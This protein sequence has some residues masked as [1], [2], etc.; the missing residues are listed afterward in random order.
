[1]PDIAQ[2]IPLVHIP[3]R[4]LKSILAF[5]YSHVVPSHE[6]FEVFVDRTEFTHG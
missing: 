4:V 3:H 2:T 1:M 5:I 6:R